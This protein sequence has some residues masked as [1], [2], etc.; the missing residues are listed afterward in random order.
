MAR[1]TK[2]L[3]VATSHRLLSHSTKWPS[4]VWRTDGDYWMTGY[5][6][7]DRL[8]S[9]HPMMLPYTTLPHVELQCIPL[10][11]KFAYYTFTPLCVYYTFTPLYVYYTRSH[12]CM[13]TTPVH[14]P[15][16]LL[17]P[18]TPLYVYYTRSHPCMFTT[19]VHTPVC[20]TLN[21]D[22]RMHTFALVRS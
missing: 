15:V 16:C 18:F 21:G 19:P 6:N 17:H 5:N 9:V 1:G 7:V 22:V 8:A 11:K 3:F 20:F 13:F 12:A 4:S 2:V 14:T 10:G